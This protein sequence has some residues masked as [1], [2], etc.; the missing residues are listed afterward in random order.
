MHAPV[1]GKIMYGYMA[2]FA[3]HQHASIQ[4]EHLYCPIAVETTRFNAS[5]ES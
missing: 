2:Y 1:E 5:P 3:V 4:A